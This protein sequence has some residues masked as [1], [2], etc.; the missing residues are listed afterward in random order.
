MSNVLI[1]LLDFLY[2]KSL[3]SYMHSFFL[4]LNI[5]MFHFK[6]NIDRFNLYNLTVKT[7]GEKRSVC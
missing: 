4:F 1:Y 3:T 5:W 7:Q 6:I 2:F